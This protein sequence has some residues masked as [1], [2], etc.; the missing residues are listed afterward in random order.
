MTIY[1]TDKLGVLSDPVELPVIPGIGV[2]MPSNAVQLAEPLSAPAPGHVWVLVNGEPQ[3]L[4]DHRGT[5][6][7]T[8]TGAERQ[9]AELGDLPEGL[10]A[11]PCPG[12]YHVWQA[13]A[14]VL[15]EPALLESAR[16]AE[17]DWR[18]GRISVT[19]YLA[20]PDYPLSESQRAELFAYRQALRDW[21]QAE[22]FPAIDDRPIPPS[23]LE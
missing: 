4:A 8:E 23:W 20:M 21:P 22:V 2:Q 14:W 13:G 5:V 12:P 7:D 15:D 10:T 19:D 18:N 9:H 3:Q 6:Y 1:V 11:E 17:R 16:L